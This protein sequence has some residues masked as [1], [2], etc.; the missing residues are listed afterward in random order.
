M[1]HKQGV[2]QLE[3]DGGVV[4]RVNDDGKIDVVICGR[5]APPIW[6]LPKG[7]PNPGETRGETALRE[8]REETGLEVRIDDFVDSIEY[9]FVSAYEGGRCQKTV[10]FYLMSATGGDVSLHDHE[11]DYVEW[12]PI[13]AAFDKLTYDNE[14]Q[15]VQKALSMV[16]KK[17]RR[18]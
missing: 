10:Y 7:T 2:K 11:F 5:I 3:S 9:W 13:E 4:Y 16:A 8:V 1:R 18:G 17:A 6:G 15:I 12:V 14:V